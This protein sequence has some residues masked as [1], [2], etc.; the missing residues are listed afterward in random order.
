MAET[1]EGPNPGKI[2]SSCFLWSSFKDPAI[3]RLYQSYS[4][5]Q[6]RAGLQCFLYAAILF[7]VYI[8]AVPSSQDYIIF[9][10][11]SCFLLL[12]LLLFLWCKM[13]AQ[14]SPIWAAVPHISW[15]LANAQL[16]AHL[17]LK[18]NEVTSRDCLGWVLLLDYLV[19]VTLPLRLRYCV[20]LSLGTCTSYLVAVVGLAK[21]D[22]HVLQQVGIILSQILYFIC[23]KLV[24][25]TTITYK[26]YINDIVGLS[27]NF[28]VFPSLYNFI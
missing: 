6:K 7:D 23:G 2:Q 12:N 16:L 5:K 4:A 13:G 15:H 22:T 1:G 17:F 20:M 8:L 21:S 27:Y 9:I 18:K 3:E 28:I 26:S 10:V 24:F 14:S 11:M 25:I 19:Y